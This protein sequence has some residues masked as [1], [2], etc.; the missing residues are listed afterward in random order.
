MLPKLSAPGA[1]KDNNLRLPPV[2]SPSSQAYISAPTA[3]HV[4]FTQRSSP[5]SQV[6]QER[7][8]SKASLNP[9]SSAAS[10]HYEMVDSQKDNGYQG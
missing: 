2:F 3:G 5:T 4:S 10:F 7:H 1:A 8:G 6:F 9:F